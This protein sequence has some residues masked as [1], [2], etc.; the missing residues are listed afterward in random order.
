MKQRVIGILIAVAAL[1]SLWWALTRPPSPTAA[2][3]AAKPAPP[4]LDRQ[5]ILDRKRKARAAGQIDMTPARVGGRVTD[6]EGGAGIPGA[7]VLLT[8]KGLDQLSSATRSPGEP[9]RPLQARTA[10]DGRWALPAVPAGR[11][12][13]SAAAVGWLPATRSDVVLAAGRDNP[14]L[15]LVLG[16]GGHEVR[17]SVVDIGGGPVE[18]VLVRVTRT[19]DSPFNFD[20]PALGVVTD[21]DGAF[22][23]QLVDGHYAVATFHPDYVDADQ[24]LRVDGGPRSLL[25]TITPAGSIEGR[26]LARGSG[27]PVEGAIVARSGEE[28][29]A[30]VIQGM[31]DDPVVTDAEG[32]FRLR[33]LP[34]GVARLSTVAR[35]YAT[36]QPV[37]VVLG[38]AEHV[39]DVEILVDVAFTISGFVVAGGDEDRGLQGVLV[40]AFS[41]DPGRLYV[42]AGPSATDGYFEIFGVLPGGYTVGA[43]GEDALPNVLGASAQVRDQDVSDVLVVMDAGVHVRGRVSPA[44]PATIS[45]QIDGEGLSIGTLVQTMSNALVRAHSGDDGGFDLHPVAAGSITIVAEA[46]DGSRGELAV[47][48]GQAD[49]DGLVV[50]LQPRASVQGRVTDAHGAPAHGLEVAFR[51]KHAAAGAILLRMDGQAGGQRNATTDEDGNFEVDGLDAGDYEISVSAARGPTLEWAEPVDPVEPRRPILLT[52]AEAERREGLVLVVEARDGVIQGVVVGADGEPVADAWVT[53]VRNDSAREWMAELQGGRE[54]VDVEDDEAEA[55]EQGFR[56][57]E[58]WG[59]AE[60]PVL[61]DEVGRFEVTGL[62]SGSYRL[63]AEAH[64]DGA[65]GSLDEVALGADVRI[66]LRPLAGLAG[67]VRRAGAPVREYTVAVKGPSSR[68]Q[69]VY[70]PDGRFVMGRLDAGDYEVLVRCGE[71]TAKAE[72]EIVEGGTPSV[73][74]D[75]GGWGSLRGLVVDAG[76]GDPIPGLSI[77][78]MGD[79]GASVGSVM[80]MFTGVG[81]KTDDEGRFTVGEVPPGEGKIMFFD[82]DAAG[83]GGGTVAVADYDVE[84]DGEAD[85]GTITGVAPSYIPP[86]ERGALGLQVKAATYAKRPRAPNAEDDQE[87]AAFDQTKRLWVSHVTPS[88]PAAVVGLVPGDEVLAVDGSPVVGIGAVNAATLLSPHHVRAGDEVVLEIEHDGSR[89]TV[90]IIAQASEAVGGAG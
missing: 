75:I 70:A 2:S 85:L 26:V 72:V 49:V 53:A 12:S 30:F 54:G 40:G 42:A 5:G 36:R 3:D 13:L 46:D 20:R 17:G 41:L 67:L 59:L 32:R 7:I 88:G 89:N 82:R 68:Q 38:V 52:V 55:A 79:G 48:V 14:G 28:G 65:R 78:V 34:S 11:Y 61:T 77:T 33:G 60:P 4:G 24:S 6:V 58:M 1:A 23:L 35:G 43:I 56:D 37:E 80:G 81:P 47:E 71:G 16:R 64:K 50:T 9:A 57:L 86:D 29:G 83:M 76:T 31:G 66:S 69:Q 19:D 44:V 87:Q 74:L 62:R 8:P 15:D 25:L 22:T 27:Q 45:V 21:E 63:R 18:D 51:G 73:T 84:A 90:T 10:A 39:R